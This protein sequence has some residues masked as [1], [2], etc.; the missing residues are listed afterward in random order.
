M[1]HHRVFVG[2]LL[3][4]LFASAIV[5]LTAMALAQPN[6]AKS[7][8]TKE[9]PGKLV[10]DLHCVRCHGSTGLGDGPQAPQL[11][12]RPPNFQSPA[13]QSQSN[14]QM[15]SSIEFGKARTQMHPWRDRLTE[16][17]MHEA[18]AYIRQL[19]RTQ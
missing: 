19:G 13:F 18:M 4:I 16:R 10:Y 17:Q 12:V 5:A 6:N 3:G 15:L 9:H 14:E 1:R 7:E 2:R 11:T 8:A